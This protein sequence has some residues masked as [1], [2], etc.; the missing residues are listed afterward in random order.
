MDVVTN[1]RLNLWTNPSQEGNFDGKP[2]NHKNHVAKKINKD[3]A[4]WRKTSHLKSEIQGF[5][6]SS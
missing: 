3:E 1:N 4:S 5:L 6:S 2:S